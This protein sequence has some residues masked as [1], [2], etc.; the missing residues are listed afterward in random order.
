[1][2]LSICLFEHKKRPLL[3]PQKVFSDTKGIVANDIVRLHV[4]SPLLK[5]EPITVITRPFVNR[6]S[7]HGTLISPVYSK[8]DIETLVKAAFG[9]DLAIRCSRLIYIP[10]YEV[11]INNPD[12]SLR[13]TYWNGIST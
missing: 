10:T 8:S 5:I 6:H 13:K 7:A 12:G 3:V 9:P 4:E 11:P 1:M 2:N